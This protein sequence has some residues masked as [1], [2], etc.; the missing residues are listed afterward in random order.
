M[1][2]FSLF[3]MADA[4]IIAGDYSSLRQDSMQD[5]A[6]HAADMHPVHWIW[7]EPLRKYTKMPFEPISYKE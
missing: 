1:V 4:K 3:G 7:D 2:Q 6:G 5:T